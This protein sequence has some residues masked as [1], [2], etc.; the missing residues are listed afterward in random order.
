MKQIFPLRRETALRAALL[1]L[2]GLLAAGLT[3]AQVFGG[4]APFAIGLTAASGGSWEGL[5]VL[6]GVALGSVTVLD[7]SHG[8][9]LMACCVLLFTGNNALCELRAYEKPWF[10]PALTAVLTAAVEGV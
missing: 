6:A 5:A 4:Y 7:F 9:R 2:R 3:L 8:L 10:L 1:L